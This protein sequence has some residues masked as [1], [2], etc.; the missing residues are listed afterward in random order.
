MI[1]DPNFEIWIRERYSERTV[2]RIC[3]TIRRC[4][5]LGI[6]SP[7]QVDAVLPNLR[8]QTR[9]AYRSNLRV[10]EDYLEAKA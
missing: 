9:A 7:D 10:L 4:T 8:A 5:A 3:R 2:I 6:R 1:T